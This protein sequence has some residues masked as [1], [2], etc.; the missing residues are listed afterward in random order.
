MDH[1][2]FIQHTWLLAFHYKEIIVSLLLWVALKLTAGCRWIAPS[3][4]SASLA[5]A[6]LNKRIWVRQM[7]SQLPVLLPL[8]RR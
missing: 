3:R 7:R 6:N 1:C 5:F 2:Y 8:R 4:Q